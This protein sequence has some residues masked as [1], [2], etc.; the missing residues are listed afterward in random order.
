MSFG[1]CVGQTV[2]ISFFFFLVYLFLSHINLAN[3]FIQINL[4]VRNTLGDNVGFSIL[5]K[6]T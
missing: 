5:P 4:Q 6:D 1:F 3:N 2:F